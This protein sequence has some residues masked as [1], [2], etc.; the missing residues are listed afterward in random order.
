MQQVQIKKRRVT[1][2]EIMI[3]IF[4]IGLIAA[5]VAYNTF[6]SLEQGKG[7]KTEANI[8]RLEA[9]L[10]LKAAEKPDILDNLSSNWEN[11]V[12]ESPLV[13]KPD[14]LMRDGA[15]KVGS[16][17]R[18]GR[19]VDHYRLTRRDGDRDEVWVTQ[20]ESRLPLEAVYRERNTGTLSR[21]VYLRWV[22]TAFPD[23]LFQPADGVKL[24]EISYEDYVERSRK[25]PVGPAPP[26]YADLL[27][28]TRE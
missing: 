26:F 11:Y 20:D 24:E 21:R 1:L 6:G 2:I 18:A 27:H 14:D 19:E 28:G 10:N 13:K 17:M 16:E 7:F 12:R 22:E 3:V 9:I 25:G 23:E 5:A 8:E 4:L 15:E